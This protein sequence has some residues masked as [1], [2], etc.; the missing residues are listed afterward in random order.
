MCDLCWQPTAMYRCECGLM[1]C[2][3]CAN[4]HERTH[5]NKEAVP[6]QAPLQPEI[7]PTAVKTQGGN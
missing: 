1:L 7:L 4:E 3:P 2:P 5:A 6:P